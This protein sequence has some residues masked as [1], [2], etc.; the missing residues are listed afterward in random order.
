L[1][2]QYI[3]DNYSGKNIKIIGYHDYSAE[4]VAGYLNR[5]IYYPEMKQYGKFVNWETRNKNLSLVDAFKDIDS[6]VNDGEIFLFVKDQEPIT[7]Q[8]EDEIKNEYYEVKEV[9]F[10]NSIV[11]RENF[12]LYE[13]IKSGNR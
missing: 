4:T 1:V 9:K 13:F 7:K 12:Y 11:S 2:A 5:D 3:S 8:E 6:I 10:E